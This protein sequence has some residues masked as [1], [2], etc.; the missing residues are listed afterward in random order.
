M[1]VRWLALNDVKDILMGETIV[2][3]IVYSRM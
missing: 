3:K 2:I 1:E